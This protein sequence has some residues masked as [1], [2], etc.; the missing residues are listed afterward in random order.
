M[1]MA[2]QV[3]DTHDPFPIPFCNLWHAVAMPSLNQTPPTIM[4]LAAQDWQQLVVS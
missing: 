3:H 2:M 4:S 1:G